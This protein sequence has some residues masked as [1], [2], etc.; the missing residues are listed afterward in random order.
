MSTSVDSNGT[1]N[2]CRLD[3]G[4]QESHRDTR[5]GFARYHGSVG[6]DGM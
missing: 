2:T 1:V 6:E 3:R 5:L 4:T